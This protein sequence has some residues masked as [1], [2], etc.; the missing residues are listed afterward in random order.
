MS[1]AKSWFVISNVK[2]PQMS[3]TGHMF[4]MIPSVFVFVVLPS[5]GAD[6]RQAPTFVTVIQMWLTYLLLL[7]RGIHYSANHSLANVQYKCHDYIHIDHWW[8]DSVGKACSALR[9][10]AMHWH[11]VCQV[12]MRGSVMRLVTKRAHST[13]TAELKLRL[14]MRHTHMLIHTQ[15]LWKIYQNY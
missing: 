4:Q 8:R 11:W 1:C 5:T 14:L 3:V 7:L 10:V 9:S 12:E 6:K 13:L 15:A 2:Y